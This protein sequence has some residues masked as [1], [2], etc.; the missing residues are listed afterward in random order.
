MCCIT[1]FKGYVYNDIYTPTR[2]QNKVEDLHDVSMCEPDLNIP[3]AVL[4]LF[5]DQED[6]EKTYMLVMKVGFK[7]GIVILQGEHLVEVEGTETVLRDAKVVI[8][9]SNAEATQFIFKQKDLLILYE[10]LPYDPAT[11]VAQ[12]KEVHRL[13]SYEVKQLT[14]LHSAF[15]QN[16]DQS[17]CLFD[18]KNVYVWKIEEKKIVTNYDHYIRGLYFFDDQYLYTLSLP[19]KGRHGGLRMYEGTGLTEGQSD[20]YLLADASIGCNGHIDYNRAFSRLAYQKTA[21]KIEIVPILHR[22]RLAF[23]GMPPKK[24]ILATRTYKDQ[25]TVLTKNMLLKT[26]NITTGKLIIQ[27]QTNIDITSYSLAELFK[28]QNVYKS[29]HYENVLLR[30]DYCLEN[31]D[32][33]QFYQQQEGKLTVKNQISFLECTEKEFYEFMVIKIVSEREAKIVRKFVFPQYNSF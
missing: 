12:V 7:F 28:N 22:N 16:Y 3:Y 23:L 21:E 25:F 17:V 8:V 26:W 9:F 32:Q 4:S 14:G 27:K 18:D 20:S 15:T 31:Y 30:S 29:H 33:R 19:Y 1:T 13:K 5:P 6:S 11:G 2:K 10:Q 24:E